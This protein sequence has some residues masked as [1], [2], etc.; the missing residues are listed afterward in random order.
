MRET[1]EIFKFLSDET[2]ARIVMLLS[3]K[4]LNVCQIACV[5]NLSQ[6]LVS[7]N[8]ST[9]YL[10]GFLN[11]RKDG[12]RV[13]YKVNNNLSRNIKLIL[14]TL[15]ELESKSKVVLN[16]LQTLKDCEEYMLKTGKCDVKAIKDFLDK[17]RN[18]TI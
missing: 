1:L 13:Y 9:L 4:E 15:Y 5:L 10:S 2:K 7:K 11:E 16:D 3:N 6:P 12:K 17:K 18:K 8:L 14:K